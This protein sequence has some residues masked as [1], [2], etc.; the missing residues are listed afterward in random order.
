MVNFLV[1]TKQFPKIII[2]NCIYQMVEEIHIFLYCVTYP[3]HTIFSKSLL[4]KIMLLPDTLMFYRNKFLD[5]KGNLI[6]L[7]LTFLLFL[8]I[9]VKYLYFEDL[10]VQFFAIKM[11]I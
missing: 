6:F 11:K 7:V 2:L 5:S 8:H 9:S 10:N 3:D 1:Y 4:Q